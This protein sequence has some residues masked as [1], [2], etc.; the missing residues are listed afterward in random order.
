MTLPSVP[1]AFSP[2]R[3]V[4][5]GADLEF[6]LAVHDDERAADS[7]RRIDCIGVKRPVQE[8]VLQCAF[9]CFLRGAFVACE[10][11]RSYVVRQRLG[12]A[13]EGNTDCHAGAKNDS[14]PGAELHLGFC[15]FSTEFDVS[16]LRESGPKAEDK[17]NGC[18]DCVEP[19]EVGGK[20]VQRHGCTGIEC[21]GNSDSGDNRNK[22]ER[23]GQDKGR[24]IKNLDRIA[25]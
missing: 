12:N 2:I 16:C 24:H 10:Y 9:C 7:S 15:V 25:A 11:R 3:G 14:E 13:V 18:A 22:N 8:R 1:F 23:R 17:K 19:S 5:A 20:E 6:L 21:L 4:K